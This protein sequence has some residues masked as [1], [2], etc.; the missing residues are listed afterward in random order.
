[1][2]LHSPAL[3]V[4]VAVV[5]AS[6]LAGC[7]DDAPSAPPTAAPSRLPVMLEADVRITATADGSDVREEPATEA[8]IFVQ[9]AVSPD[10]ALRLAIG[11]GDVR[12]EQTDGGDAIVIDGVRADATA[13]LNAIWSPRSDRALF[14]VASDGA[15]ALY[16]VSADGS[17]P[18]DVGAGL[19][20]EAFPLAWSDD[21]SRL[22][23]GVFGGDETAPLSTL[24]VAD[25]DGAQ[26][27]EVG[28]F[29]F[30]QGDGG[31]DRPRFSPDNHRIVAFSPE[32]GLSLRIFNLGGGEANDIGAGG[33]R[34]F[35]WSPDGRSLAFSRFDPQDQRLAI[36]AW[37]NGSGAMRELADGDWP[38]WSPA[39]DR[40]AFKRTLRD[41]IA[42]QVYTMRSDGSG[43]VAVGPPGR[44][45]FEEL[46][47][48]EGGA[49]LSF[50][51]PA[52]SASQLYR[53]DLAAG[54][55]EA[56]GETIGEAGNPPRSVSISPDGDAA[57]YL[58]DAF[59]PGGTWQLVDFS[60]GASTP[61][62]A[63]GFPF[64]DVHWA[65]DG[66]RVALGGASASVTEPGGSEA[67]S[68]K[69]GNAHKVVFSP[70]GARVAVLMVETLMIASVEGPERDVVYEGEAER[71]IV[72]D[73]DWA[74][75]GARI[76]FTVTHQDA[77]GGRAST[78]AYVAALGGDVREISSVDLY[79]GLAY[80]S[81][82]GETLAQVRKATFTDPYEAWLMD[83][84]GA[85]ARKLASGAGYCCEQLHWSPD[86][87]RI[88]VSSDL[89]SVALIEVATGVV[90]TAITTGGGCSVAIAGWSDDGSALYA[91]PA[92]TAGI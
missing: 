29:T 7:G 83:A 42:S 10:G 27:I 44:Y 31:W 58:L 35:S 90:T 18:V 22:A 75:D 82:D 69:T 76:T 73:V 79:G 28:A 47:W 38:R 80:W 48:S 86:G 81:P 56:V 50:T 20:G 52:F 62:V 25:A 19:T 14:D 5:T 87:A 43:E 59:S 77:S 37:N 71:D 39:G 3:L 24:Y 17:G 72:Q 60:T 11:D 55:A 84:D 63:N 61:L 67:R 8:D 64:A 53:V 91:Y 26:R 23:F 40:I 9:R 41:G 78:S 33:V 74:P 54:R 68:L 30:P 16:L 65:A 57:V 85:N 66:P 15:S 32:P 92:C 36:F 45:S 2:K 70:D 6:L 4:L 46:T 49:E 89:S 51:R 88:A 13:G 34:K 1:M 12:I 21:G